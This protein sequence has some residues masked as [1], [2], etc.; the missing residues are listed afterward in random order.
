M[1]IRRLLMKRFGLR[2]TE[3][4]NLLATWPADRPTTLA[5]VASDMG[6]LRC[7]SI[8]STISRIA[9]GEKTLV[10]L[11]RSGRPP[12]IIAQS[13][14]M[15]WRAAISAPIFSEIWLPP[16]RIESRRRL[17]RIR[18]SWKTGIA[19][20][21]LVGR[22]P[23]RLATCFSCS[24]GSHRSY[25]VKGSAVVIDANRRVGRLP[26]SVLDRCQ[27]LDHAHRPRQAKLS[28]HSRTPPAELCCARPSLAPTAAATLA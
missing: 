4:W 3:R 18:V 13:R 27:R 2:P 1:P 17:A 9:T 20:K 24:F 23:S 28:A 15:T 22:I 25:A 12:P 6:T 10:S 19:R 8:S 11:C 7:E 14:M 5:I 26:N 16:V 21:S